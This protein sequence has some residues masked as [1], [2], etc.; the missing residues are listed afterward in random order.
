MTLMYAASPLTP[1]KYWFRS[2]GV[3]KPAKRREATVLTTVL[4]IWWDGE[5]NVDI[6]TIANDLSNV[7]Q[8]PITIATQRG[9]KMMKLNTMKRKCGGEAPRKG[10]SP[11]TNLYEWSVARRRKSAWE[12]RASRGERIRVESTRILGWKMWSC[13]GK[14]FELCT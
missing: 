11:P 10:R 9:T 6:N 5:L 1:R 2:Q 4:A 14:E 7:P 3:S 13:S 8:S 12:R